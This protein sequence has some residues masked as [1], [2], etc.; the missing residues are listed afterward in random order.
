M[1]VRHRIATVGLLAGA[2]L[3]VAP[4][5]AGASESLGGCL[6]EA[7]EET[8]GDE[9]PAE[10]TEEQEEEIDAA[11]EDCEEAPSPILPE[12]NEIIWGGLFFLVVFAA[13]VKFAFPALRQG[14]QNREDKI[15]G[16]LEDAERA[17]EQ[18]EK[19]LDEY[20]KQL[21][22]A[23]EEAARILEEARESA[24]RVR[25]ERIAAVKDEAADVRRRADDDLRVATERATADLQTQ[26]GEL[27]IELAEK[28]VEQS[29]DH[30]TQM[31]LIERYI[32]EVGS[33]RT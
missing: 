20:R 26:V 15:R 1:K 31:A 30:D 22:N 2:L 27:A 3:V 33:G 13:L 28:V 25:Q 10:L 8:V 6:R 14:L 21:A 7:F 19:E 12:V 5:T 32:E 16:D 24:D 17:K 18:A 4:G 29:L 23:R 11:A 9:I